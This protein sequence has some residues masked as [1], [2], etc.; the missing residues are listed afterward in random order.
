MLESDYPYTSG[1]TGEVPTE[2]LF[3]ASKATS[4]RMKN[5]YIIDYDQVSNISKMKSAL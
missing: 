5:M 3:S 1:A 4:I 2:C